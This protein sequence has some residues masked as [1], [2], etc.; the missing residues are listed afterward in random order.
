MARLGGTHGLTIAQ[1]YFD[2]CW[3][4]HEADSTKSQDAGGKGESLKATYA[5]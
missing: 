3:N 2:Q 4:N 1:S 5:A